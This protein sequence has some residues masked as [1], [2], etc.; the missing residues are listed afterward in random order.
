[1]SK[2]RGT[3]NQLCKSAFIGHVEVCQ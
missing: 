3:R 1:M 2:N